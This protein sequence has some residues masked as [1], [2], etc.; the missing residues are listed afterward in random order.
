MNA[1]E[2]TGPLSRYGPQSVGRGDRI[3]SSPSLRMNTSPVLNWNSF[4]NRTACLRLSTRLQRASSSRATSAT[5]AAFVAGDRRRA[6]NVATA[7]EA[8]GEGNASV[9]E[10]A[11]AGKHRWHGSVLAYGDA[12]S[13]DGGPGAVYVLCCGSAAPCV[14]KPSASARIVDVTGSA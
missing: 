13:S 14:L 11:R 10:N 9:R 8:V 5:N 1:S 4:G 6:P 7:V 12:R 2:A 3:T